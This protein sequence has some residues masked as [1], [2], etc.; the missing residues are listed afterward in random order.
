MKRLAGPAV[1]LAAFVV[2]LLLSAAWPGSVLFFD[3]PLLVVIYYALN[4]GPTVGL[5]LG[6]A[7]GLLQDGLT[8][9]LL[10]VAA[11]SRSLVGFLVGTAVTRFVLSGL[12][13]RLLMVASATLLA[14]VL[15]LFTLA[16]M[17]R[18]LVSPSLPELFA[19][20][21]G[22]AVLGAALFTLIQRERSI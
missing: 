19:G 11:L 17:G 9:S 8:G 13:A 4:R 2:Q 12:L 15:D 10:G 5:T 18:H 7:V 6:G 21:A 16:V 14:R 3:L 22:N 1:L 20:V